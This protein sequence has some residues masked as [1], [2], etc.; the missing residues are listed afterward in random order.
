MVEKAYILISNSYSTG[1][2]GWVYV[3][4]RSYK[5]ETLALEVNEFTAW[6][7]GAKPR[8]MLR[9]DLVEMPME[10][11]HQWVEANSLGED[12]T[13]IV[14]DVLDAHEVKKALEKKRF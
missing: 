6:E 5:E 3:K 9:S 14:Q 12:T 4:E 2:Y 8:V 11:Y 1:E 13:L 10:S 7:R